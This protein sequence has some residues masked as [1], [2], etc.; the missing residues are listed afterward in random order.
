MKKLS[1]I[2]P[3]YNEEESLPHLM[4][5]IAE[6]MDAQDLVY[7][8]LF[9]DDGS[10]DDS[11]EV[12]KKLHQEYPGKIHVYRFSRNHGKSA[13]LNAGINKAN[14]DVI[15]TMDADLQDDPKAIPDMLKL[16]N[17]G[18]DLVSGWKKKRFDPIFTKRLP[19]KFFNFV[20]SVMSGLKIHDFNCG[21]KAYRAQAAKNIEIYGERHRYLPA[22]V[23]WEGY[24]VTEMVVPHHRRKYGKTKFGMNRFFNGFFDL[25]T[26]LF[27][28][29]YLA[30]PLHFFGILG[31]V[32]FLA[33]TVVLGYFGVQWV[34]TRAMHIRPLVLL[35]MGS[36]IMGIQF[37]FIGLIG[38]MIANTQRKK[39]FTIREEIE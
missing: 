21:F 3:L 18:W 15:I 2:I 13:A 4:K 37:F 25:L 8:V 9:V 6:V 31:G 20:T 19:S 16:I 5:A 38:E 33:G 34:I 23:H 26:L 36:I 11:F 12:C 7:E 30:N 22:L 17:D 24:K 27:L 32:F 14:G 39:T 1:I 10:T 28:R 29:K 35:S